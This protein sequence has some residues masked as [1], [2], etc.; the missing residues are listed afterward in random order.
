MSYL[1]ALEGMRRLSQGYL[2][3]HTTLA[4][5]RQFLEAARTLSRMA[6]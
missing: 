2:A 4:E 5:V 1:A 6:V 3:T